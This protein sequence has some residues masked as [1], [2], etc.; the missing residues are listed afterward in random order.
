MGRRSKLRRGGRA[1]TAAPGGFLHLSLLASLH[2]RPSLQAHAQL[3]LLG[4][5]LPAP[6][7]SLLLRPHLRSGNPFASLRLFLRVL[8]DRWWSPLDSQEVVPDSHSFSAAL[9]ACSRHASPSPG[10]SIHA[11]I[12][13]SGFASDIFAANSLLHFYGSFGLHSL[14]RNLFDEMPV[15]DTV[16]FNTLISS[17]VHSCCINDAFEVFRL[18]V[19]SGFR[20]DGW[21]ITALLAACA[22]LQDLR[23][24]KS[25]HGVARR[26]LQTQVFD[27]GEVLT[28]LADV[29]VNCRCMALA[30][31]V[32]DLA[33]EKA[34]DARLWTTM[35][36]AY[37]RIQEF[38]I[39]QKLFHEM[40]EK[41]TIT[42]TA[43][44]GGFVRAGRY[45]EAVVLFEEMEKAGFEADE[46]TV[47]T[48]LSACVGYGNID[49]AKRLHLR[50]GRDGLIG[51]NAKL[52]TTFV[53]MYAK[54]GCIQ[55]A[56]E[57]F[58]SVDDDFKT[59]E[60][61]N[62]MINGL[63]RCKFGEKAIALFDQMGLLG[64]RPDK[65]T[66][67]GL[68]SQGFRIFDSMVEKYGVKPEIEHYACMADLLARDGQLDDAY[69]FIQNMPFK[70]NSVVW[71]SLLRA[72]MLH[73]NI[74]IRKL[75]EEQLLRLDPNYKPENLPLSN[76]FSDR[77][78]KERA[79]RL[80]KFM[81]HKPEQRS[82]N[83]LKT[84]VF[85]VDMHCK[86]NGCIK[87]IND[88]MKRISLSEG[89]EW[90]DLMVDK[91]EV[92]VV[93]TMDLLREV[94]KKHVTIQLKCSNTKCPAIGRD[95]EPD[96]ALRA[97]CISLVSAFQHAWHVDGI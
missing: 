64:L 45:L 53:D 67:S 69:L 48:V 80:R 71:S 96:R 14:T 44:I 76:L 92:K 22:E 46:V 50:M 52:A 90:A 74:R 82:D 24:A 36:S 49:L 59:L 38:D 68:V 33:G 88:G 55:T 12:L 54:H 18:M 37:A 72:C 65:I 41:D 73:G 62:A 7:A 83:G 39:A 63:A 57:V 28:S 87:K 31:Q 21:T 4:L 5:P 97:M 61:F 94:T 95:M 79:A 56:E 60:L 9:A 17:Y 42:W 25:V 3:L 26:M 20:P 29:Y 89:V 84:F 35:V 10:L 47:V 43:L 93:G 6:T 2:R 86:C 1:I 19:E 78:R 66:H 16:S 81:N 23:A 34:R 11:F 58:S 51:R 75:A 40:P 30:R 85:N 32:F 70:A 13:K 27:S 8:R 91:A 77:K 15:R